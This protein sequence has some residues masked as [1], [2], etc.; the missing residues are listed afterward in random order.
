M[1]SL[2]FVFMSLTV[3]VIFSASVAE[4]QAHYREGVPGS[5]HGGAD[6]REGQA[7]ERL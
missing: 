3:I 2:A 6:G 7:G 5:G 4:S 1:I